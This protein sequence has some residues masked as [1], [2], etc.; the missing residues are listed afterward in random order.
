MDDFIKKSNYVGIKYMLNNY[1]IDVKGVLRRD[2]VLKTYGVS[3]PL[4]DTVIKYYYDTTDKF[5]R[6][7][8]INIC[9]NVYKD[10]PYNE[11]VV[12][13]DSEEERIAFLSNIPDTFIKKINKKEK[14]EKHYNYIAVAIME[15]IPKGLDADVFETVRQCKPILIVT[16]KRERY[17]IIHNNGLKMV[18]S[19]EKSEFKSATNKGK[20]N[21]LVLEVRL[22]SD[23]STKPL[24]DTLLHSLQIQEPMLIKIKHSDLF[25]GQEYLDF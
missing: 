10:K 22:E 17:R 16:K 21:L 18:F 8:G 24:L 7:N 19:F 5:F 12:R 3:T 20:V 13:Y 11:I 15:L 14:F 9:F 23:K 1:K 25:I 6:K 2:G 4:F